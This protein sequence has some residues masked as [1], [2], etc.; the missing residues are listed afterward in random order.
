MD[1][2]RFCARKYKYN[3]KKLQHWVE[4]DWSTTLKDTTR[5]VSKWETKRSGED[6]SQEVMDN[7]PAMPNI[8][9]LGFQAL[10]DPST[11]DGE[12]D[13]AQRVADEDNKFRDVVCMAF[14]HS[15]RCTAFTFPS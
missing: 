13:K 8:K 5:V 10:T 11:A 6:L 4:S 12:G 9:S 2:K 3:P 7:V 15:C 14:N 1:S